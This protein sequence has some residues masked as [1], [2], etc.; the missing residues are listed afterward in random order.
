MGDSI[1]L[2][3]DAPSLQA[4]AGIA[5][6]AAVEVFRLLSHREAQASF[7]VDVAMFEIYCGEVVDLL[8]QGGDKQSSSR[9]NGSASASNGGPADG[10]TTKLK[11]VLAEHSPTGLV[12][13][14]GATECRA[15]SLSELIGLLD[16][17]LKHRA[18]SSTKM[19]SESSRSHLLMS[20][21]VTTTNRRTGIPTRGKL[22]L[23]DLAGRCVFVREVRGSGDHP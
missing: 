22:T 16:Q 10:L 9:A 19:N 12:H 13:V 2:S 11:I 18:T 15:E 6:R 20:M 23:V 17:G 5:Q 3:G 1:D 8:A 21:V 14:E 4:S 7:R